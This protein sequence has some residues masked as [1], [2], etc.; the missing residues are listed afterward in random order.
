MDK[1][2]YET[3]FLSLKQRQNYIYVHE[4]RSD[5]KLVALLV[6][7]SSRPDVVLGR[8]EICPAHG[9][10]SPQLAAITGGVE[11]GTTPVEA[12]LKELW[13]E[14]GYGADAVDL[15]P[16]G[17]VCPSKAA[18]TRMYLY[19]FDAY[20][21]VQQAATGDGSAYEQGAYCPRES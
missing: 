4:S 12:A 7:D 17:E 19:A 8:Y 15:E 14:A 1:T 21:K 2:L 18:D 9:D 11:K 10:T 20:G 13:E 6:Y 16:L 5:G 3:P